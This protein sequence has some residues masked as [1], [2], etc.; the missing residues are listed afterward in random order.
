L[1]VG[2][3]RL[4]KYDAQCHESGNVH[5]ADGS[6]LG[7]DAIRHP[8][9]DSSPSHPY[10]STSRRVLALAAALRAHE[11][12]MC[13]R[14]ASKVRGSREAVIE[15]HSPDFIDSVAQL[16]RRGFLTAISAATSGG[17]GGDGSS[18][19]HDASTATTTT[20]TCHAT[21]RG[22][23]SSDESVPTTATAVLSAAPVSVDKA[24]SADAGVCPSASGL[25]LLRRIEAARL[26]GV[27]LQSDPRALDRVAFGD[28]WE[29]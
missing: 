19:T 12:A 26:R 1:L 8:S 25:L 15:T 20:G 6:S 28:D 18:G 16:R 4:P 17:G 27:G 2:V 24:A 3:A 11:V 5:S 10:S 9:I 23:E 21:A 14:S 22:L 7:A 29:T 13:A